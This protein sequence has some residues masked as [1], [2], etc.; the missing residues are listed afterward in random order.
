MNGGGKLD[1]AEGH[2]RG[3][4]VIHGLDILDPLSFEPGADFV[5][6]DHRRAGAVR[7]IDHVRDMIA[8]AVRNENEI[9]RDFFH[10][11]LFGQRIRGDEWIEEQRFAGGLDGETGVA[12]VS[13]FHGEYMTAGR[14]VFKQWGFK[15]LIERRRF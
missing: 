13:K 4:T 10:V 5:G 3:A 1:P 14:K 11:N 7:D 9:R 6:R 15:S 12:V 2:F 8:V